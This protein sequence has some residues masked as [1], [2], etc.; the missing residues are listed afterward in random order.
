MVQTKKTL[1]EYQTKRRLIGAFGDVTLGW[2]DMLYLD[3]TARNDWSSTLPI[4]KNSFFY[5]GATLSW[6][7]T[8][9]I[10]RKQ[11]FDFR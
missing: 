4:D 3:L 8:K 9:V 7:F 2:N 10:P 6:I 5:P 11:G 1:S